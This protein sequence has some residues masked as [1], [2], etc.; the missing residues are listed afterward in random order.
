MVLIFSG[1][2]QDDRVLLDSQH[3]F[4]KQSDVF[5]DTKQKEDILFIKSLLGKD[6]L[7]SLPLLSVLRSK[8]SVTY[9]AFNLN[10]LH[11]ELDS[12]VIANSKLKI[13]S[14]ERNKD[15]FKYLMKDTADFQLLNF[16]KLVSGKSFLFVTKSTDSLLLAN[17]FQNN[18]ILKSI[19]N[20]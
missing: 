13:I 12:L 5:N 2:N 20:N 6:T 19:Q 16:V 9:I 3:N 11:S 14:S 1:C 17:H 15:Y 18:L 4:K 10:F 8:Q 7:K